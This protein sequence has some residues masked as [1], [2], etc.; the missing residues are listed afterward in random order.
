M[1][2]NS[3]LMIVFCTFFFI[4][5]ISAQTG[6][7]NNPIIFT[8]VQGIKESTEKVLLEKATAQSGTNIML[9]AERYLIKVFYK[10]SIIN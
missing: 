5:S 8:D 9:P 6:A 1:K 10:V 2:T 3:C 4:I 7:A